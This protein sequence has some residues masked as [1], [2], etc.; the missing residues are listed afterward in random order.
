MHLRRLTPAETETSRPQPLDRQ[1]AKRPIAAMDIANPK[2]PS[3]RAPRIAQA[4]EKRGQ[5]PADAIGSPH[6]APQSHTRGIAPSGDSSIISPWPR[7]SFLCR[8]FSRR[9]T[10]RYS[11]TVRSTSSKQ[12]QQPHRPQQPCIDRPQ[13]H[14]RRDNQVQKERVRQKPQAAGAF[15]DH[16][17]PTPDGVSVK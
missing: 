6:V 3:A 7:H 11:Q 14:S 16:G 15:E 12:N 4:G 10:R 1:L 5:P 2:R 17:S 8:G 13:Q 9:N